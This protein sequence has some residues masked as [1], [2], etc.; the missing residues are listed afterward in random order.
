MRLIDADELKKRIPITHADEFENCRN[1]SLLCDWEVENIV[2]DAP[3]IEPQEF[4]WCHDCKEYDQEAHCCHRWTKVIRQAL[5]E[6][7]KTAHWLGNYSPYQCDNCGHYSD[8]AE[9]YC[10]KC[11]SKMEVEH[12]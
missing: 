9:P 1:C 4:E 11:G 12:E 2:D 3:T 10:C 6:L 8:T 7:N 5:D